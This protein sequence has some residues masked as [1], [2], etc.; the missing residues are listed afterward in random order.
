M[1][2]PARAAWTAILYC[3]TALAALVTAPHYVLD[4]AKSS[5]DF[6]F[7]QAG[8]QNK[9]KFKS[10]AVS[11]D[12]A[13]DN[14]AASRLE[15]TVEIN[16]LDTG[17]SERDETLRG[18]DM[19]AVAKYP[20]AHFLATQINKT[21]AGFEAVGQLTMRGVTRPLT[22]PFTFRSAS[23]NAVAVGY[24]NGKTTLKRLDY[25]VGQGEWKSTD[26]VGND[27]VV[28]FALRL[29]SPAR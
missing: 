14:L 11:F 7:V 12:F 24:M 13:P 10:F 16:S 1:K 8:A 9:G 23:E 28:G 18:T 2:P 29:T 5:L 6:T 26:G 3:A 21:A 27:V 25:G 19:F 15:V 20:Q 4:P 17:D 22:V